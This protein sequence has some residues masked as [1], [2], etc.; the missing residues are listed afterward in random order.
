MVSP[1]RNLAVAD[2]RRVRWAALG[3]LIAAGSISGRAA[4][5][6]PDA[7]NYTGTDATVFSFVDIGGSSGGVSVLTGTDDGTAAL[8]LPFTFQFYGQAYTKICV[9]SNGAAYFINDLAE[10]AG[11]NDFSHTDLSS[12]P[13]PGDRAG[14]FPLWTDLTFGVPGA[15][16]VVYQTIG[17]PGSQKFV[18]QWNNAYPQGSPDPV[19]F[20]AILSQGS[21]QVL[22]Q[23]KKVGLGAD[24][25]ASNG[26]S[27]SIGI[28]N[29]AALT[30]N[31]NQQIVWSFDVPVI[32]DSTALLFVGDVTPPVITVVPNPSMLWPPN[33]RT[34]S[35]TMT[36]RITDESGIN[37]T[38][39]HYAVTDS[40]GQVQ[41]AGDISLQGDGSYTFVLALPA[42]RRDADQVGRIFSV[43]VSA[44]DTADNAGST[45]AL[46]T[47]PHDQG[48]K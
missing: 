29:A 45:T 17:A 23:Y 7:G 22:F 31:L 3:L 30:A 16:S 4:T 14:L 34:V 18:L 2:F 47:V 11:F 35:V 40:Y 25:P 28:R 26:K 41:P 1:M 20:Q 38:T 39:A 8:T 9:S 44:S 32:A 19:T 13:P 46:V 48:K 6:G 15:G 43:V 12:I 37:A 24:N 36:G 10:C 27:A 21:N 5:K 33:G 42:V